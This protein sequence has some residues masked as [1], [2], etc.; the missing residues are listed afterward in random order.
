MTDWKSA[1][2]YRAATT[3]ISDAK[4]RLVLWGSRLLTSAGFGAWYDLL[5]SISWLAQDGYDDAATL[6]EQSTLVNS[7]G[8]F[9]DIWLADIDADSRA[10]ATKARWYLTFERADT[11][12]EI[13]HDV[14]WI[15]TQ[16]DR[17]GVVYRFR[18]AEDATAEIGDASIDVLYEA[19]FAGQNWNVAEG[20]IT[21]FVSSAAGWDSVINLSR[22]EDSFEALETVGT[23]AES[24]ASCISRAVAHLASGGRVAKESLYIEEVRNV[25][26][27][28]LVQV[29]KGARGRG[30]INLVVSDSEGDVV[31]SDVLAEIQSAIDP[32]L[33]GT[34]DVLVTSYIADEYDLTL[35]LYCTKGTTTTSQRAA[36]KTI[37]ENTVNLIFAAGSDDVTALNVGEDLR[38]EKIKTQIYRQVEA[39][40]SNKYSRIVFSAPSSDQVVNDGHRARLGTLTVTVQEESTL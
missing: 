21:E 7:S 19:E 6:A 1:I 33:A 4:D 31:Y 13:E 27:D 34:D 36:I 20:A 10:D 12:T 16:A 18:Q 17:N 8:E 35:T 3:I 14:K 28:A 24:D 22:P 37:A 32:E 11:S 30:T 23:D 5:K 29:W 15:S 26:P 39:A 2:G 9:V 25:L 40:Y 38:L